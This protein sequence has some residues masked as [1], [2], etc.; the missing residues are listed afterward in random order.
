MHRCRLLWLLLLL[1]GALATSAQ[2]F[3]LDQF[4]QLFRP[5]LRLEGR[6]LPEVAEFMEID[7]VPHTP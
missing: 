1:A 7:Y 5:R 2:T 3:D 4:D 6:W